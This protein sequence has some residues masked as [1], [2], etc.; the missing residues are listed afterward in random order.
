MRGRVPNVSA[1]RNKAVFGHQILLTI[2]NYRHGDLEGQKMLDFIA[3]IEAF[4]IANSQLE[5]QDKERMNDGQD[6]ED[7]S[8]FEYMDGGDDSEDWDF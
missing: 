1:L 7:L 4:I 3:T 5:S 2:A 8:D 6:K